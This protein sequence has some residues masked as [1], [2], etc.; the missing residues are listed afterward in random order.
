MMANGYC[1]GEERALLHDSPQSGA[2]ASRP[3]LQLGAAKVAEELAG[4]PADLTLT[5][6]QVPRLLDGLLRS[7]PGQRSQNPAAAKVLHVVG[8]RG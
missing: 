5:L 8:G 6:A 4:T 1:A 3:G 2:Y 7:N